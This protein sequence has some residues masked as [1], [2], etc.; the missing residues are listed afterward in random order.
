MCTHSYIITSYININD[1]EVEKDGVQ[2]ISLLLVILCSCLYRLHDHKAK[3]I[4]IQLHMRNPNKLCWEHPD[5]DHR[6]TATD[7]TD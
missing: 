5:C 1:P 2:Y 6:L 3:L 4:A 7:V